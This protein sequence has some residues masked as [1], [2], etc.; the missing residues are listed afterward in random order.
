MQPINAALN[1]C[2]PRGRMP[3]PLWHRTKRLRSVLAK[4]SRVLDAQ[5]EAGTCGGDAC[6]EQVSKRRSGWLFVLPFT[7]SM[8]LFFLYAI[9]RTACYSCYRFRLVQGP[10]FVG[11][12]NYTA[13]VSDELFLI[14]LRNTIGFSLIVHNSPEHA[15]AC[16]GGFC[17][18]RRPGEGTHSNGVLPA[19]DHVQY[20]HDAYLPLALSERWL[21]DRDS[22]RRPCLPRAH[23]CC[24]SWAWLRCRAHSFSTRGAGMKGSRSSIPLSARGRLWRIDACR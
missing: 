2:H 5:R 8:A 24:S 13:L 10:G 21:H 15:C 19:V 17:E 12:S 14:A 18:S 1:A 23:F 3:T 20:G 6:R 11:L 22:Q 16:P 4:V 7:I 9:V